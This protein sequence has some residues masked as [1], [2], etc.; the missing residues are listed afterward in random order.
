M[1]KIYFTLILVFI[2]FSNSY[3]QKV[4]DTDGLNNLDNVYLFSLKEYCLTLDSSKIKNVYVQRS[5]F[6][7]D[8]WPK[9]INGFTIK[10]LD[11]DEYKK[12]IKE[13]N[14]ALI[15]VGIQNLELRKGQF[16]IGV[17]S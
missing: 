15:I 8:S 9:E 13:N 6:V 11:N 16:S 12:V 5:H 4:L 17:G 7:G 1:R 2:S 3:G 14:G 10:Y